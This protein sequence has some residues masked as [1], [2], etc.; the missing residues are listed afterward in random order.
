MLGLLA[1]WP[2]DVT[3]HYCLWSKTFLIAH[4]GRVTVKIKS[5]VFPDLCKSHGG[6]DLILDSR[7]V[8][9]KRWQEDGSDRRKIEDAIKVV[10]PL[11]LLQN[12]PPVGRKR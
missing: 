9:K 11:E 12:T 7:K 8:P 5:N 3:G 6:A 4:Q 10:A 1:G 2:P